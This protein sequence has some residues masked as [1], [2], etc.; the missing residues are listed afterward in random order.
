MIRNS[1][2]ACRYML[3]LFS[4]LMYATSRGVKDMNEVAG[5]YRHDEAAFKLAIVEFEVPSKL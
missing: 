4:S 1:E 3:S 5:S 2:K